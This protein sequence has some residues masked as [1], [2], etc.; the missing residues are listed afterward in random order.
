MPSVFIHVAA[1]V[2]IFPFEVW[3]IFHSITFQMYIPHFAYSSIVNGHLGF[4][5][6]LAVMNNAA[7]NMGV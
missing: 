6:V 7:K 5:C 4:F 3:I 2:N 1:Y